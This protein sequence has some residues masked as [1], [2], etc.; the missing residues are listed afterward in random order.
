MIKS[1]KYKILFGLLICSNLF[2]NLRAQFAPA[3]G[4][5]GTTAIHKDS[6]IIINW[7]KACEYFP[8]PVD[9]SDN[10]SSFPT[11][12]DSI[13]PTGKAG[14]NGILSLGDGGSAILYFNPPIINDNGWDFCVFENAFN[15]NF[16][17]LGHVEVS[18]NGVDFFRFPSTSLT[19]DSIQIDAFGSTNPEEINNLA[20]KYRVNYGTPFDLEELDNI[21][22]LNI[23]NITHIKIIDVIGSIDYNYCS[24]DGSNNKINDP[25]PTP[26]ASSGF[27]LEAIGVIHEQ[28]AGLI[29]SENIY[30]IRYNNPFNKSIEL[31]FEYEFKELTKITMYNSNGSIIK[32][33]NHLTNN[34]LNNLKINTCNMSNGFYIL[35][36]ESK[37]QS[38]NIKLIKS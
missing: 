5:I 8:G 10:N 18:S 33:L 1:L 16:L 14:E 12:G 3:V 31:S 30:N 4:Q 34:G 9:I 6:S 29:L 35:N 22:G 36:I 2:M 13:S 20:G 25:W 24:Y 28:P 7:A 11:V 23:N 38:K 27:D 17:E 26:F 21:L 37:Y 19:Q 15:D 32:Q